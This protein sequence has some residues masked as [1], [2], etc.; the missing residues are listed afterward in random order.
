[1]KAWR[2]SP[3]IDTWGAKGDGVPKGFVWRGAR[4]RVDQVCNRWRVHT[5]WWEP[6]RAVWR[7]YYKV[8]TDTGILCQIYHDLANG[9]WFLASVYD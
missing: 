9:G 2:E 8:V 6:D 5:R 4:H 7:E 1:M 3:A